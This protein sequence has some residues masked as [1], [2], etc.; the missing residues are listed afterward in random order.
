[1]EQ[2]QPSELLVVKW[3]NHYGKL[4]T[5]FLKLDLHHALGFPVPGILQA[6]TLEWVAISFSNTLT[7]ELAFS[8]FKK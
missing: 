2:L 6:R 7:L 1:M 3:S 5:S 8:S 4:F